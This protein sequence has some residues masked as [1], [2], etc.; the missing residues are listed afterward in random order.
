VVLAAAAWFV[1]TKQPVR[2]GTVDLTRLKAPVTVQYDERGVP[3]IR[4]ENEADM[5]RALGFVH[6]QDRLFQM[7]AMRRL[8]NGELAEVFGPQMLETDKLFRTLGLRAHAEN[9][10]ANMDMTSPAARALLAYL[11]G[12][13]QYQA[14]HKPPLEFNLLHIPRRPFTPQDTVSMTGYLAYSFAAAFKTEPVMTFIRD[15][16][17]APYLRAFD[18]EWHPL[19]VVQP[20]ALTDGD[21]NSLNRVAEVS[22]QSMDLLGVP[23]FQGSN[24]WAISGKRTASGKPLLAGD[25]HVGF[26]VPAVWYE[27]HLTAPGFDL[28]GH[29]QALNPFALLGHN[30]Q[31]GWSLTMFEND[32]IDL[33]AEQG[34]PSNPN[35]IWYQD[36]WTDLKA[37]TETIAVK[38]ADS[39][40]LRL[41][42]SPR[43][44]IITDA[45][46]DN[47]G[48]TPVSLWWTYLQTENPLLDAFYELNRASTRD[49]ARTAAS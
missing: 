24:A 46:K 30:T 40:Q 17:G 8:A 10:V 3:H 32:D 22:R 37:R 25:P 1:Y 2:S 23:L 26:S 44:P 39:V 41:R 14:T 31:F 5:Y 16:L 34:N 7:E 35:Q 47:F 21:W 18:T 9:Y 28:Y 49:K 19:G 13:N 43:G 27:A 11:D 29:F 20:L 33:V 6:A 15:K 42:T 38:D 12:V 4:A 45:F 48:R 36:Q